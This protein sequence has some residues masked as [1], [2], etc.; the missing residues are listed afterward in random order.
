MVEFRG[1]GGEGKV[2]PNWLG[3]I[4]FWSLE[5][6]R[7]FTYPFFCSKQILTTKANL[8]FLPPHKLLE[9]ERIII[10]L[11]RGSARARTIVPRGEDG[12]PPDP[13]QKQKPM[14]RST[15]GRGQEVGRSRRD[16]CCAPRFTWGGKEGR[17]EGREGKGRVR[18][19]WPIRYG[20]VV[21]KLTRRQPLFLLRGP[22]LMEKALEYLC[23]QGL[24]LRYAL[25]VFWC[26]IRARLYCANIGCYYRI[27][28]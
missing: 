16:T 25:V 9:S 6:G 4:L 28:A 5:M 27:P 8:F 1:K 18:A 19:L 7:N 20:G 14:R 12:T 24:E 10:L 17:K 2:L 13:Q 23:V 15:I 21:F 22:N 11:K 26:V 3:T